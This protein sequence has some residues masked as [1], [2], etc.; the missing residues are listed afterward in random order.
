MYCFLESL[1]VFEFFV[2]VVGSFCVPFVMDAILELSVK[3]KK[4]WLA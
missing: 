2:V 4:R 1:E 3:K